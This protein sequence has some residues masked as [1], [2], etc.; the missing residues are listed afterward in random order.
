V[1]GRWRVDEQR[2]R[3]SDLHASSVAMLARAGPGSVARAVRV[4]TSTDLA[5]VLGSAQ[6]DDHVDRERA[7]AA[8]ATV[9][10]RR[11]GGG[12]VMVGPGLVVWIDVVVPS[13]D[14]LWADDVGRAGWW[15]GEVWSAALADVGLHGEVWRRAAVRSPW[16]DRVCFAGLGAGEV[17][18]GGRKV[19]GV[20]QRRTRAG[21]LFQCAVP[22]EWDPAPLVDV[23]RWLPGD[24]DRAAAVLAGAATGI[25]ADRAAPLVAA[26][27]DR[28]P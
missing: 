13:G 23:L 25:G 8:G 2:A 7:A 27:L 14:C 10:R 5:V 15:L 11:S 24:A 26:F 4:L 28:L 16:S 1:G 21:A 3:A 20:S 22:V 18:I 17:T 9:V 6:P 19:L 12:A